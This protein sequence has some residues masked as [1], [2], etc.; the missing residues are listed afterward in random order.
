MRLHVVKGCAYPAFENGLGPPARL[1]RLGPFCPEAQCVE[2]RLNLAL[3]EPVRVVVLRLDPL[4]S[5][6][7]AS[8]HAFVLGEDCDRSDDRHTCLDLA[9]VG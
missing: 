3:D 1:G 8:T 4:D 5:L 2:T 9:Q 7:D 6:G